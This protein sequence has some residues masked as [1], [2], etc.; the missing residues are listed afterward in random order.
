M[1]PPSPPVAAVLSPP[2]GDGDGSTSGG[3]AE[4]SSARPLDTPGS[5]S[6]GATGL[7]ARRRG[8]SRFP[9]IATGLAVVH[10]AITARTGGIR[11]EHVLA[12][13]LIGVLPWFGGGALLFVQAALPLWFTG[14]LVEWQKFLP[15]LGPVR[16]GD[17]RDLE[18][19]FFR[20]GSPPVTWPEW[21]YARPVLV[22]DI[23]CGAAYLLYLYEYF[24]L[25][26]DFFF[27][28]RARFHSFVWAFFVANALGALIYMILPVAPPW[29]ILDHGLGP[30]DLHALGS[31]AGCARFDAF[32]GIH[33]FEGFYARN[34]NV[35]GAMPSLHVS[36]PLMVVMFTW[37]RGWGWRLGTLAFTALVSF[38]AVYLCHH[39][40]LDLLAGYLVGVVSV[41]AGRFL[42][43]RLQPATGAG[44]AAP[45][46]AVFSQDRTK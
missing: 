27:R 10:L 43:Q 40:V 24:A 9:W 19:R 13:G 30:A 45:S 46:T 28:E 18:L 3:S 25:A 34:P 35:F 14:V 4:L 32:F 1:P 22:L 2:Q 39:Y 36:Y 17:F 44:R 7:T 26:V 37:H 12:D 41:Y 33:Y 29:Y 20:A 16:T 15:L 5:A 8:V 38:A 21:L 6:E 31:A 23:L 11:W 42:G